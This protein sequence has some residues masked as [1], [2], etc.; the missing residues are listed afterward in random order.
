MNS[1]IDLMLA[2]PATI[3]FYR[4]WGGG[5][6]AAAVLAA[7]AYALTLGVRLLFFDTRQLR[8]ESADGIHSDNESLPVI[9]YN[10]MEA[11]RYPTADDWINQDH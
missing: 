11:L 4:F 10:P 9:N 2:P 1:K 6:N 7:I 5:F 3:T 8:T